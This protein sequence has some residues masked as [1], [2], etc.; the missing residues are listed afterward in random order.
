MFQWTPDG[1]LQWATDQGWTQMAA[2]AEDLAML[3]ALFRPTCA[4]IGSDCAATVGHV[5]G[6]SP[7]VAALK[8]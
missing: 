1:L 6:V 4:T 8:K 5:H 7:P 3:A 2:K